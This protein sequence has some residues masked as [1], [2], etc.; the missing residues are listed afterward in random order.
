[1]NRRRLLALL[2][3]GGAAAVAAL[4]APA[5]GQVFPPYLSDSAEPGEATRFWSINGVLGTFNVAT[6][7]G[8]IVP[9]GA[10]ITVW[11]SINGGVH[12]DAVIGPGARRG[13][14]NIGQ[15]VGP[16]DVI[17]WNATFTGMAPVAINIAVQT[18]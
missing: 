6:R 10:A 11:V 7:Y 17:R 9:A 3:L 4:P 12:Y 18:N 8:E 16:A 15:T 14:G 13:G 2:G 1:M 5:V